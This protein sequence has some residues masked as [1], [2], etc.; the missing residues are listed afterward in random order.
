MSAP[1]G[2]KRP[3]SELAA[4]TW[5]LSLP[6][7]PTGKVATVLPPIESWIDTGFVRVVGV[8]GGSQLPDA[9]LRR[10][11]V[12]LDCWAANP[13][14]DTHPPWG[15][16]FLLAEA[17]V[18]ATQVDSPH[19]SKVIELPHGFAPV[20]VR[21]VTAITEPRRLRTPDPTG[22]YACVTLD[23]LFQWTTL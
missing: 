4:V 9:P 18:S 21:D 19:R 12:Q 1:V 20:E 6:D 7:V 3:N 13:K 17:L 14:S 11:V 10:P 23:L 2:T 15:A 22:G 8:V 5:A 16:A